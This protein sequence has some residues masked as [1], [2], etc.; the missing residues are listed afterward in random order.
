M[1]CFRLVSLGEVGHL[2]PASRLSS[3]PMAGAY[4]RELDD[5]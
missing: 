3:W 4:I 5:V 2:N 1:A